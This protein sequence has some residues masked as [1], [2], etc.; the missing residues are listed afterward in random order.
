LSEDGLTDIRNSLAKH[1]ALKMQNGGNVDM[2]LKTYK[3]NLLGQ[4]CGSADVSYS[5][6]SDDPSNFLSTMKGGADD[7]SK[8]KDSDD[9]NDDNDDNEDLDEDDEDDE[10]DNEEEDDN[11]ED[12]DEDDD[13]EEESSSQ[14][15]GHMLRESS[16]SSSSTSSSSSSDS[17]VS[18]GSIT[19]MHH[20]I[21]RAMDK[22]NNKSKYL[23]NNGY[24]MTSNS[25]DDYKNYKINNKMVYS[26]SNSSSDASIG[27][28][29]Y[30]NALRNR[31]RN[32]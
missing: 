10:D 7:D 19:I 5:A 28:S 21:N 25:D 24:K 26:N 27:G 16:S 14:D 13:N 6:T 22:K 15:G 31:D 29:D 4:Q 8:K 9:D 12:E 23:K 32:M 1:G 18:D 3:D 17:D 11:D 20:A 2:D 30:L